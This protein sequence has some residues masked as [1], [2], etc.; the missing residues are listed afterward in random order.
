[1]TH[2]AETN[3]IRATFPATGAGAPAAI[4]E[5]SLSLTAPA[6]GAEP[7]RSFETNQYAARVVW[8]DLLSRDTVR[9]GETFT[10]GDYLAHIT[11]T[12]KPGF[13]LSGVTSFT[14]P[15]RSVLDGSQ[16]I[17]LSVYYGSA[18]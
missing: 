16:A 7:Q 15:G 5:T 6:L 10:V 1:M 13:T 18:Q 4:T 12:P 11:L 14:V 9:V 3:V 17:H 2:A 8:Y